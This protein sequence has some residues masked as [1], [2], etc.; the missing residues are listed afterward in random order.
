M[1]QVGTVVD[2]VVFVDA[3]QKLASALLSYANADAAVRARKSLNN[4]FIRGKR[5]RVAKYAPNPSTA[6]WTDSKRVGKRER[7]C[8]KLANK[9]FG[10]N[11]WSTNILTF[12]LGTVEL[13]H[14]VWFVE[15]EIE[16]EIIINAGPGVLLGKNLIVRQVSKAT[17]SHESK[18]E[19]MSHARK[20]SKSNALV[21]AFERITVATTFGQNIGMVM[22]PMVTA[23]TQL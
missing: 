15:A 7:Q 1:S 10:F 3:Q 14:G 6:K 2:S 13:V 17:C 12:G 18:I 19:A 11:G 4:T 22:I 21:R 5:I 9:I 23:T 16:L 8:S 20:E